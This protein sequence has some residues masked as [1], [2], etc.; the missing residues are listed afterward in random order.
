MLSRREP[1]RKGKVSVPTDQ[2]IAVCR[3]PLDPFGKSTMVKLKVTTHLVYGGKAIT[4]LYLGHGR[5]KV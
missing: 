3:H 4:L 2:T 1:W 5:L